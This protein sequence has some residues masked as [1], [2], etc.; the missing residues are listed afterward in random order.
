MNLK[1]TLFI[2][3]LQVNP[4]SGENT[5]YN[6]STVSVRIIISYIMTLRKLAKNY[7]TIHFLMAIKLR[8]AILCIGN[9]T[10]ATLLIPYSFEHRLPTR[11]NL[12]ISGSEGVLD[13]VANHL[14]IQAESVPFGVRTFI[15]ISKSPY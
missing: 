13:R 3:S 7:S 9:V 11:Q 14:L 8:D 4:E 1:S 5:L 15:A 10:F 2:N 12:W 6:R